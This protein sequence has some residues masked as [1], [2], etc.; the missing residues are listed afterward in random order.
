M[1]K[2]KNRTVYAGK[3]YYSQKNT[4]FLKKATFN[5]GIMHKATRS[6]Q[7]KEKETQNKM[8]RSTATTMLWRAGANGWGLPRLV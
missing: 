3:G 7:L 5:D 8:K 1:D 2:Q 4:D 6:R